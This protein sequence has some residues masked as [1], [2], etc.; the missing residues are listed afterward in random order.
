M[1]TPNIECFV[2]LN[3]SY[4]HNGGRNFHYNLAHML[5]LMTCLVKRYGVIKY[6]N[7]NLNKELYI[8]S[9]SSWRLET[10]I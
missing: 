6:N 7:I 5:E 4:S 3:W 9:I 1:N 8:N 10:N 2:R